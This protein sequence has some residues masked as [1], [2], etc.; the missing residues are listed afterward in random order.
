ML[1]IVSFGGRD[2]INY[3]FYMGVCTD[4]ISL[5]RVIET[6]T[7]GQWAQQQKAVLIWG[8]ETCYQIRNKEKNRH[9]SLMLC[10]NYASVL[11]VPLASHLLRVIHG[12]EEV[13]MG[14][15]GLW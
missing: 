15:Y 7:C 8:L 10:V 3:N 4:N 9:S 11:R 5:R 2:R 13:E 12:V 6:T 1:L 14:I